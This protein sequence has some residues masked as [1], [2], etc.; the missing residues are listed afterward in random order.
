MNKLE[1][2]IFVFDFDGT[3]I[4]KDSLI[5][6]IIFAKGKINFIIGLIICSPILIAYICHLFPNWKAKQ[7]LFSYFFKGMEYEEF[8]SI[9]IKFGDRI[10]SFTRTCI[11]NKLIENCNKYQVY[12]ISA[13]VEEWIIP[14]ANKWEKVKVLGT[15]VDVDKNGKLTGHFL[16]KNCYGVEKVNRLL[17]VEPNK[18][19]YYLIAYGDS[20]GDFEMSKF[21][22]EFYW[23]K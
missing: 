7:Y 17:E 12:I 5:E 1:K 18:D 11:L 22:N 23:I 14:W 10:Q 9:G 8:K 4:T 21:A 15:K 3:L 6:F 16:T 13:S 20:K 2:K 19:K